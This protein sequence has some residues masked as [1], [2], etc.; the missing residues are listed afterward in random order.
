MFSVEPCSDAS[1]DRT[2][3]II[4][5]LVQ[6]QSPGWSNSCTYAPI[7]PVVREISKDFKQLTINQDR[8]W[9]NTTYH[10]LQHFTYSLKLTSSEFKVKYYKPSSSSGS[11]IVLRHNFSNSNTLLVHSHVPQK[12]IKWELLVETMPHG[13]VFIP[14]WEKAILAATVIEKVIC[15]RWEINPEY[16]KVLS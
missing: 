1:C 7:T 13:L 9:F 11:N 3:Q 12:H 2:D 4:R 10:L 8:T 16:E 5:T 15:N 14:G 6:K